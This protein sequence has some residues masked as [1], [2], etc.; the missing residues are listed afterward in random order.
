[1]LTACVSAR[2]DELTERVL[3]VSS[4]MTPHPL[5]TP[6]SARRWPLTLRT[7]S[8]RRFKYDRSSSA[9][10][11][12]ADVRIAAAA[13]AS[14]SASSDQGVPGDF[15]GSVGTGG[16]RERRGRL[17][18]DDRRGLDTTD[19]RAR[20]AGPC[21]GRDVDWLRPAPY[22][23]ATMYSAHTL[24]DVHARAHESLRRLIVFCGALD[25]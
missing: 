20:V 23:I 6:Q 1:M 16:V 15:S 8:K 18:A 7:D 4:Q 21:D 14:R 2:R 10:T 12:P 19:H 5:H 24:L 9:R 11:T 25:G 13:T 3:C 17:A 22:N